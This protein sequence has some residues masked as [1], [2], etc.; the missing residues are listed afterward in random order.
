M[1]RISRFT[2]L[3]IHIPIYNLLSLLFFTTS[4]NAMERPQF[5]SGIRC[6]G[7]GGACIAVVN[8]ETSLLVNPAGLGKLKDFFGTVLDPEV[9]FSSTDNAMF[10]GSLPTNP[11][12]LASLQSALNQ[13]KGSL[14]HA[15]AQVFP[16]VVVRNFGFGIYN[17]YML[18]AQMNSAGTSIDT[19]YRSDLALALGYNFRFFDGR[20]KLGVNTKLID[21]SEVDNSALSTSGSLD[22]GNLATE[23]TGLSTDVGLI[24]AA[25]WQMIPTIAAVLHDVGGTSF[26][27]GAGFRNTTALRPNTV[28][29]DLNVAMALFPIHTNYLRSSWTI[30]YNNLLTAD[31]EADKAKLIHAGFELNFRDLLFFRAGYNQ[32]YWTAGL[33]LASEHFQWQISSYGQEIGTVTATQEDRR[34]ALKF[35]YRF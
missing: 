7:M 18:D 15:K 23:G 24:L 2:L 27:S 29:Q 32:R 17:N 10:A 3:V 22:L 12:S 26:T 34:Y 33:E 16:S 13:S 4:V 14:F 1:K 20:L 35:A 25:P 28:S 8:D 19:Y 21:R 6:L 11:F 30:Q 31:Q 5:Y 9:E